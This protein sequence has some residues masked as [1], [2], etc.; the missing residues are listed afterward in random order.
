MKNFYEIENFKYTLD[1]NNNHVVVC[2][3]EREK[4][5]KVFKYYGLNT[6]SINA[7]TETNL[8][9][10]HPFQFNDSIDSSELLLDFT[11]ISIERYISFFERMLHESEFNK[12]NW[13]KN[14]YEDKTDNFNGIR[15]FVYANFSRNYGMISL[16]TQPFNIL[17]WSHYTNE[18][19]FVIEF[20]T[21]KLLSEIKIN[22]DINNYCFR[23]VQYL[24]DVQQID[25]F[26]ENFTTPDIP[27]LYI[28]TIKRKEW[29][30]EDEWRLSIYKNSMDIPFQKLYP[31]MDKYVGKDN[32]F[33]K[34]TSSSINSINLGKHFFNGSNCS[35]IE[36]GNIFVLKNTTLFE[37]QFVSFVE[38]LIENYNE[39]L[40]MSGELEKR[41]FLVRSLGKIKLEKIS[42]NKFKVVDLGDVKIAN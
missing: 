31:A 2:T 20:D 18:T 35:S 8:F 11:N 34:Y 10:T 30:Y 13:Q 36:D 33:F 42:E 22:K 23:P 26:H 28:T 37:K 16:T 40:F 14:Y 4:P 29:E 6:N 32:R 41:K 27:L 19:G 5:K 25:T 12:H 1:E 15:R 7:L 9:A 38:H 24:S 3:P 39:N 17:M 21:D